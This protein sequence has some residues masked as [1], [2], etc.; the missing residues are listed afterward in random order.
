MAEGGAEFPQSC[1]TAPTIVPIRLLLF[2]SNWQVH[3]IFLHFDFILM[4]ASKTD[5]LLEVQLEAGQGKREKT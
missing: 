2:M 3:F 4:F 1:F 5:K